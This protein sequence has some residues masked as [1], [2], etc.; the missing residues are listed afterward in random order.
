M[1]LSIDSFGHPSEI[2]FQGH[3]QVAAGLVEARAVDPVFL[4]GEVFE[5]HVKRE[6]AAQVEAAAQGRD[7][8]A[9]RAA[10]RDA[11]AVGGE[12]TDSAP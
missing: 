9:R 6:T 5:R 4:V 3:D 7:L 10:R 8:V 12:V 11:L 1:I 2:E